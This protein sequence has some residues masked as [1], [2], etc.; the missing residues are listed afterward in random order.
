MKRLFI[1][2]ELTPE[3]VFHALSSQFPEVVI[4]GESLLEFSPIPFDA[5]PDSDWIFFSSRN[6]VRFFFSRVN[7]LHL[8]LPGNVL[9]AVLGEGTAQT[10]KLFFKRTPDFTGNGKPDETGPD[11]AC[12]C[13]DQRVL[14]PQAEYS[15]KSIQP[16]L[17]AKTKVIDLVVYGNRIRPSFRIQEPDLLILTSPMNAKAFFSTYPINPR[18]RVVAIGES[19]RQELIRLGV[20]Q[21]YLPAQPSESALAQLALELLYHSTAAK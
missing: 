17:D 6:A 15:H 20:H 2:R 4:Q 7:Q 1:S 19:T 9:W 12:L 10:L 13:K 8:P 14:F 16:Y 5:V 3:S 21:V 11:F 18:Q